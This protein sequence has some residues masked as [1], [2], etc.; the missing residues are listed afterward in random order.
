M[1]SQW[2]VQWAALL[3][4]AVTR[5]GMI[6]SAYSRFHG[7]SLGNQM[8]ALSQCFARDIDPGP[9]ASFMRWKELG[10]SVKA[11][12]KAIW[13]CMPHTTTKP[14]NPDDPNSDVVSYRYFVW[15]PRWFVLSQTEGTTYKPEPIPSWS[16]ELA[17]D[18]LGIKEIPF[19]GLDGNVQGYAKGREVAVN[20]LAEIPSKTLFHEIGHMLLGHTAEG[21]MKEGRE[22]P[23]NLR[24]AEAE[25]V[26]LL[27]LDALNLTGADYCRGYIQHWYGMGNAIPEA[28]AMRIFG[29][30]DAIL[31]A[32]RHETA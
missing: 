27:C 29:E 4:E 28:S 32:G 7:Y 24:E 30:A 21:E 12:E 3:D 10:R 13:L 9:L 20:P 22:L 11:G 14:E 15:K 31:R 8:A 1:N 25:S 16:K 23:R 6:L 19:T 17:L 2:K 26:A 18:N 5:P